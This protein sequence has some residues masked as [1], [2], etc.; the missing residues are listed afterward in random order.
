MGSIPRLQ[1]TIPWIF[2]MPM[3]VYKKFSSLLVLL[4]HF[5]LL[6]DH[7]YCYYFFAPFL[8]PLLPLLPPTSSPS[9]AKSLPLLA[10]HRSAVLRRCRLASESSLLSSMSIPRGHGQAIRAVWRIFLIRPTMTSNGALGTRT[11]F[12]TCI[13]PCGRS[14]LLVSAVALNRDLFRSALLDSTM[15]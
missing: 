7:H 6:L 8:P 15:V 5:F 14:F 12:E 10:A 11:C 1:C 13:S 3:D 9:P 2:V 4:S